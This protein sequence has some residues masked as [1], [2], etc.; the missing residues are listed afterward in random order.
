MLT[1][2]ITFRLQAGGAEGAGGMGANII[3]NIT[4]IGYRSEVC[5]DTIFKIRVEATCSGVLSVSVS[6]SD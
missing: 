3:L 2:F 1:F 6:V 5:M 4:I